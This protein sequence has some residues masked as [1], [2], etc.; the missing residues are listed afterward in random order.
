MNDID[1]IIRKLRTL[2]SDAA[3]YVQKL[4]DEG[5]NT[6]DIVCTCF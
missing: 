4:Y 1:I 3:D 5:E 6:L 2:D